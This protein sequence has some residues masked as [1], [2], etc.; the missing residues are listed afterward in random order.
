MV[1]GS[2]HADFLD[3][4]AEG[5]LLTIRDSSGDNNQSVFSKFS[6][7]LGSISG[8]SGFA[9]A[10]ALTGDLNS[11]SGTFTY[12]I[13]FNPQTGQFSIFGRS[14]SFDPILQLD[15]THFL[16]SVVDT[17]FTS[18]ALPYFGFIFRGGTANP[19]VAR[20]LSVDNVVIA[21]EPGRMSLLALA[22]LGVLRR[23]RR[24]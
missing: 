16:G 2:S 13:D 20:L 19:S 3:S 1:I 6:G 12:R 18:D 4:S 22:A 8:A 9:N 11:H 17:T 5:Y 23:R 10:T 7:G 21:P 14:G 24:A 15:S